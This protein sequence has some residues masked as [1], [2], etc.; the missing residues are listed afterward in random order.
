MDILVRPQMSI[1]NIGNEYKILKVTGIKGSQ[2]PCHICTK[3]AIIFVLEGEAILTTNK[4]Q[5]H[6]KPHDSIII[7][8][9]ESHTLSI[10]ESFKANVVMA[11]DSEIK[12]EQQQTNNNN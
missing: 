1:L 4:K 11:I 8:A 9:A 7:N 5:I 2:M 6:L 10:I 3:E 12:F